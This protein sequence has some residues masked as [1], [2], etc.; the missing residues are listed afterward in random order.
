MQYKETVLSHEGAEVPV[1][2][3]ASFPNEKEKWKL[4]KIKEQTDT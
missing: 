4:I 3:L 1:H 2:V